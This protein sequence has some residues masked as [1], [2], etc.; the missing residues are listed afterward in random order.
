M[1][2]KCVS[3]VVRTVIFF[4]TQPRNVINELLYGMLSEGLC[5]TCFLTQM[6]SQSTTMYGR[7]SVTLY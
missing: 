7:A 5:L 3:I 1:C 4:G 2:L 6:Q